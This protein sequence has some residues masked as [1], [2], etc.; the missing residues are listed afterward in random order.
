[1]FEG[2]LPWS[3]LSWPRRLGV[4]SHGYV[5]RGRPAP[6]EPGCADTELLG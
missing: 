6:V 4:L 2:L 3:D 1:M 5:V